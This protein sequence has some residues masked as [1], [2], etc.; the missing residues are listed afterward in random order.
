[1]FV[2]KTRGYKVTILTYVYVG[3]CMCA[4]KIKST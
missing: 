1:M 4:E 2:V 3:A